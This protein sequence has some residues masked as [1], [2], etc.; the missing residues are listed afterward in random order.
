VL[1]TR[2][3]LR[4]APVCARLRSAA[5][6]YMPAMYDYADEEDDFSTSGSEAD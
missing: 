5:P 4:L 2:N 3:F 6:K 1:F